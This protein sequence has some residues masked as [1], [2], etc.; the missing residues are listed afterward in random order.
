MENRVKFITISVVGFLFSSF[1]IYIVSC[2]VVTKNSF[3]TWKSELYDRVDQERKPCLD[4][5]AKK[6]YR[7]PV[8][9]MNR[10]GFRT[11]DIHNVSTKDQN[12]R[13][14]FIP[15]H[16]VP[17]KLLK[18]LDVHAKN[19]FLSVVTKLYKDGS[20]NYSRN[21]TSSRN[22]PIDAY[23]VLR[24]LGY[25]SRL[26]DVI[27]IGV[28][29]AGTT[30]LMFYLKY[31][32]QIQTSLGAREVHF[33]DWH[34]NQGIRWYE[35]KMK[36]ARDDQLVFEKTPRYFVNGYTPKRIH[37]DLSDK[38]RFLLCV[39]DPV[40]RLV[41]DFHFTKHIRSTASWKKKQ[42]AESESLRFISTITDKKGALITDNAFV[43]TSNYA[44]HFSKWLKLF[45]REKFL[46]IDNSDMVTNLTG[47]L[48]Q[49]EMFLGLDNFFNKDLFVKSRHGHNCLKLG[50]KSLCPPQ[51][52]NSALP[53]PK[54]SESLEVQLRDY[55]RPLNRQFEKLSG[56]RFIWTEL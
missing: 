49:V 9:K 47:V 51:I 10:V 27:N 16:R 50:S 24:S 3:L 25:E 20:L 5:P 28:K 12:A 38:I 33:F 56:Q 1:V 30:A 41:S 36:F 7:K 44:F 14:L 17:S 46:I 48:Q 11:L 53:K 4:H 29:K 55:F 42:T 23:A 40:D 6:D 22:V 31:H 26:P 8:K 43:S 2:Q 54:L 19:K 13:K 21:G 37:R 52:G 34:Y 32:P 45:D 39:R 35:S 18:R 15:P